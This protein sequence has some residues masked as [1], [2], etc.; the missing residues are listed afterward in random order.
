MID[1][2]DD[3]RPPRR[4]AWEVE[5]PI[6]RG[7]PPSLLDLVT[8]YPALLDEID[9]DDVVRQWETACLPAGSRLNDET[10][11]ARDLA[12]LIERKSKRVI[13]RWGS[14]DRPA[15]PALDNDWSRRRAAHLARAVVGIETVM[16]RPRRGIDVFARGDLGSLSGSPGG[17]ERLPRPASSPSLLDLVGAYATVRE[18]A[19]AETGTSVPLSPPPPLADPAVARERVDRA[20]ASASSVSLTTV[21]AVPGLTAA[22][23]KRSS[24]AAHF[25]AALE[26]ARLGTVSLRNGEDGGVHIERADST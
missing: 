13:R 9:V 24:I 26:L 8:R 11:H 4:V 2:W 14:E 22:L 19:D 15:A 20:L 3:P 12:E 23:S 16:D 17:K 7:P 10:A 25:A 21:A 1:D 5:T 18:N 6:Y